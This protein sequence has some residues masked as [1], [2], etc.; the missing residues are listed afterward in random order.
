LL[1]NEQ[2]AIVNAAER[3]ARSGARLKVLAGAGTGKTTT[4][5]AV[6]E[7][8][9][10]LNRKVLYLAYNR[11][12]MLESKDRFANKADVMT[13]HGLAYRSMGVG[14]SRRLLGTIYPSVVAKA[15]DLPEMQFGMKRFALARAILGTLS[16]FFTSGDLK[17]TCQHVPAYLTTKLSDD[18]LG[19]IVSHAQQ[20]FG[21]AMP[22]RKTDLPLTH[23]LYLK[24]WHVEG[25]PGLERYD[26]VLLDEAQD[27]NP[28][29][30]HALSHARH[31]VF[32]GDSNQQIYSFRGAIDAMSLLAGDEM[33]LTQSFRWGPEIAR[34]ANKILANKQKPPKWPLRGDPLKESVVRRVDPGK[35][36]ARIYRTNN[37]LM[38]DALL[39]TY[40]KKSIAMVGDRKDL[41]LALESAQALREGRPDDVKHYLL[42]QYDSW[43]DAVSESNAGGSSS[44]AQEIQQL[45]RLVHSYGSRL[46][47]LIDLLNSEQHEESA[48]V[49]LTTAHRAKG[50]E[51][52]NVVITQ[53][54]DRVL[55]NSQTRDK[56]DLEL[57]LLYVSVTRARQVLEIQS[58]V[59]AGYIA[60]R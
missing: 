23:D 3:S 4:L 16:A 15:L 9:S 18:Q 30:V 34:I 53:D 38:Q 27:A 56:I 60:K 51:W 31:A 13:L 46:N 1:T 57:N 20:F 47:D 40:L 52:D 25:T 50:R 12:I 19:W 41:S 39:L 29:I 6:A 49:V 48:D 44:H 7:R 35:R 28:V 32:V 59:L 24:A 36:H 22:N 11:A 26:T 2:N 5:F 43:E 21:M 17:I 33:P 45:V 37:D 54:F 14:K 10:T 58:E 8:L 42:R 55:D